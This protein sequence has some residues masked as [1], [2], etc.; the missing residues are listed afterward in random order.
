MTT[1][2]QI[3]IPPAAALYFRRRGVDLH[4]NPILIRQEFTPDGGWRRELIRKRPSRTWLRKRRAT[5]VTHVQLSCSGHNADFTV[6][7]L[8]SAKVT[9]AQ[10]WAPLA[11]GVL[12]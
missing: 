1:S 9:V 11:A 8:L 12:S 5:G 10:A 7:E 6:A 2:H 4:R 3:K